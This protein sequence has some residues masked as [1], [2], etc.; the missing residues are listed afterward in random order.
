MKL[1]PCVSLI[2]VSKATLLISIVHIISRAVFASAY[3][4]SLFVDNYCFGLNGKKAVF[5]IYSHIIFHILF[6]GLISC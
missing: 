1:R 4:V 3:G 2:H 6:S 5:I